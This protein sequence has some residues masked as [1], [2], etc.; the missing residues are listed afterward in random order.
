MTTR[1]W[2]TAEDL[3]RTRVAAP[4]PFA[5]TVL[6]V[7][8]LRSGLHA[9]W[10]RR[11]RPR[12]SPPLRLLAGLHPKPGLLLD[13]VTLSGPA[14]NLDEGLEA[15][16]G[17]GPGVWDAE[18]EYFARV[19]GGIPS[20]LRR[21]LPAARGAP[22]GLAAAVR[23]Y[24]DVAVGP[25]W[26][27]MRTHLDTQRERAGRLIRDGG[28]EGL[29][30]GLNVPGL[31]WRPPVLEVRATGPDA[32]RD[33]HLG[34]RGL[35]LAPST[36]LGHPQYSRD[37][38]GRRRNLLIYPAPPPAP[39]EA[40]WASPVDR[41]LAGLLGATRARVLAAA[42]G[43]ASTSDL[44]RRAGTPLSSASEHARALR[45]A[46]LLHTER[47]GGAVRH[48]LTDLGLRLLDRAGG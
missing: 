16:L 45:A 8:S 29:F 24:H 3:A 35:L 19:N 36:F 25:Y 21:L 41:A 34:G 46:G 6:S 4:D 15:M 32:D 10:R 28:I 39:A 9:E 44:A 5:E 43:G 30:T 38:S 17:A 2:F 26:R 33:D 18:I 31:R 13:L 14:G 27:Q 47:H 1:I 23:A 22:R 42:G 48:S 11:V 37:L 20:G 12:L 40:F 7:V